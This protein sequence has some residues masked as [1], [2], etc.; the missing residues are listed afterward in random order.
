MSNVNVNIFGSNNSLNS[1]F[2]LE[3][4]SKFYDVVS[5]IKNK[6]PANHNG[7]SILISEL[8]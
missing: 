3:E 1:Q 2:E 4:K 5:E 8:Y 6:L 7:K